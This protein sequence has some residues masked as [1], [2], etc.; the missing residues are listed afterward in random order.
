MINVG[1]ALT[2]CAQRFIDKTAV[3]FGQEKLSF[4][5]INLMA[6][7]VGNKLKQ[8]GI[9]RGDRIAIILPNSSSFV[10]AY[11]AIL[12]LGAVCVPLDIRFK[13]E[14]LCGVI[15]DGQIKA[16]IISSGLNEYCTPFFK[17]LRYSITTVVVGSGSNGRQEENITFE[18]IV[19]DERLSEDVMVEVS[20][21]EEALYLYTSGTTGRPKGIVLTFNNLRLFPE[22]LAELYGT[23]DSE[24]I[25]CV[26]PMS[27]ISGPILCNE[28]VDKGC[29]LVIFDQRRP[30]K[31]LATVE[32]H[33]VTWFHAVPPIFQ[34]ILRV[35]NL[36]KY[37]LSS[38]RFIGMMGT[39]VP[40]ELLKNFKKVFPSVAVIQ[41][42]GLTETSPFITLLPLEYDQKKMGSIGRAVPHAE[43]QL[44]DGK[45]E[46]VPSG[47]VGELIV[48]G[49]M[50]MK[51]YHNNSEA[52]RE[53]IKDGWLYTG[54]LCKKDQDGFYYH[55]GR[56]DDIII[57]GGL[58]VFPSEVESIL[59][60]HPQV[61]EAGAVGIPDA[62]RGE[63]IKAV[64]VLK[65]GSHL[66][67]KDVISYCRGRLA[68]Y[69]VPKI[70]EFWDSIPKTS[71]G[72]IARRL[73]VNFQ[74]K[75]HYKI[76]TTG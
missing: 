46:Q 23:N 9:K 65:P 49:P 12:K 53:R 14:E 38:L 56:R 67:K 24:V 64:V 16:F 7:R 2:Q 63:I 33:K 45:G 32:K 70:V 4:K 68:S 72:K 35:P 29:S 62:E 20:A 36:N 21:D 41:G 71:T 73:L 58:N 66:T 75:P 39:S 48:K 50:V 31:I 11:F 25:G 60:A 5:Q 34:A 1:K 47:E 43:I 18:E 37:E 69:K 55:L 54:D 10:I 44:V 13:G 3:I 15:E 59:I 30:D 57:V 6:N 22:T 19:G 8:L 17:K 74:Q 28:L 26:L 51:E 61:L 52:T 27:H 42:Y 40:L 76:L